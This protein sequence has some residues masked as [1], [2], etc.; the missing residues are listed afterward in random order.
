MDLKSNLL[1]AVLIATMLACVSTTNQQATPSVITQV[2]VLPNEAENTPTTATAAT[3]ATFGAPP[4]FAPLY[5]PTPTETPQSTA[6]ASPTATATSSVPVATFIK[7]ANCRQGPGTKYEVV[8][9]FLAGQTVEIV[10]RNP[11][12]DNTWWYVK[13]PDDNGK[14]WVSLTTAQA[15]G[16]FDA[17]P[18]VIP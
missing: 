16:D 2:V 15:Y 7:N 11:D 8:T 14:C 3:A 10:G 13:I 1:L 12:F 6:S 9:S 4:T 18:T 5:T 17:I